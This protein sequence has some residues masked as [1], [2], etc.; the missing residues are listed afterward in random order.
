[1]LNKS[2]Q[3]FR[4]LHFSVPKQTVNQNYEAEL[5]V[6]MKLSYSEQDSSSTSSNSLQAHHNE[7]LSHVFIPYI[8]MTVSIH[9]CFKAAVKCS[10]MFVSSADRL[11]KDDTD[12]VIHKTL[13]LWFD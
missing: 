11:W 8:S 3:G 9:G 13:T 10:C 7:H 4:A 12:K 6:I 5:K 2:I 1:M